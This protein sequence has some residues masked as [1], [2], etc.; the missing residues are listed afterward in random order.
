V[1]TGQLAFGSDSV[2]TGDV[3]PEYLRLPDAELALQAAQN[4]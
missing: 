1:F 4:R 2:G 3:R